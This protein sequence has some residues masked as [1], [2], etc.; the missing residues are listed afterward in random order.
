MIFRLF[1]TWNQYYNH[2]LRNGF[3]MCEKAF[4]TCKAASK[5]QPWLAT[6]ILLVMGLVLE[7]AFL[8]GDRSFPSFDSSLVCRVVVE[9]WPERLAALAAALN[10]KI[11]H[12]K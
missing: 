5:L 1:T 11:L 4:F 7:L 12:I 3:L 8:I 6:A 9:R 2:L 10:I